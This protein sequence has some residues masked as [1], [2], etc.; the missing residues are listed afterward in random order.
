M[1]IVVR[2][3]PGQDIFLLDFLQRKREDIASMLDVESWVT[4]CDDV[5]ASSAAAP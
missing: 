4:F 2:D 1:K 5:S 3:E